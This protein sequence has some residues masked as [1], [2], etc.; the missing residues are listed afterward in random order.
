MGGIG[1]IANR[2]QD[3]PGAL[4]WFLKGINLGAA[5]RDKT[6]YLY[7]NAAVLIHARE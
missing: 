2:T 6:T 4:S 1:S 3:F 7:T 5:Y